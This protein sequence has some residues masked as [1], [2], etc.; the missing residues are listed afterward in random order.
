MTL[1]LRD[2]PGYVDLL[3]RRASFERQPPPIATHDK[4]LGVALASLAL[5]AKHVE[6]E[7]RSRSQRRS[8][9]L[10]VTGSREI[11]EKVPI[12]ERREHL[13]PL[14]LRAIH[15]HVLDEHDRRD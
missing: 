3:H 15:F 13:A 9:Y 8:L 5:V 2:V 12:P 4:N 14:A 11:G 6:L 10:Q 7:I 1:A